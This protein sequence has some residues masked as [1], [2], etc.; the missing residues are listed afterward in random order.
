MIT[1]VRRCLQ[2]FGTTGIKT[3]FH[4]LTKL[5]KTATWTLES[6]SVADESGSKVVNVVSEQKYA[7]SKKEIVVMVDTKLHFDEGGKIV[8]HLDKWRDK[9]AL[10]EFMKRMTGASTT[11]MLRCFGL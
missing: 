6:A 10:P 9:F 3:Q 2:V 1:S 8:Q 4:S 5:F 7:F 11:L